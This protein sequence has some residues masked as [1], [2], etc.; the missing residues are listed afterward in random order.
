M[1]VKI[2]TGYILARLIVRWFND[3]PSIMINAE[4]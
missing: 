1:L 2:K 3:D 4:L